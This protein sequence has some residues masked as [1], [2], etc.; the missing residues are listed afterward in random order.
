MSF[1][2]IGNTVANSFDDSGGFRPLR[3]VGQ[4]FPQVRERFDEDRELKI[5]EVEEISELRKEQTKARKLETERTAAAR[6]AEI[7]DTQDQS[8][9]VAFGRQ[10]GSQAAAE[11][12][13]AGG[14]PEQAK[15]AYRQKRFG[16]G[17]GRPQIEQ[18]GQESA[19]GKQALAKTGVDPALTSGLTRDKQQQVQVSAAQGQAQLSQSKSLQTHGHG[20]DI[21]RIDHQVEKD[22]EKQGRLLDQEMDKKRSAMLTAPVAVQ[23]ATNLLNDPV[24]KENPAAVA[25]LKGVIEFANSGAPPEQIDAA[26]SNAVEALKTGRVVQDTRVIEGSTKAKAEA[27]FRTGK[28]ALSMLD[29]A[30]ALVTPQM[31]QQLDAL[32]GGAQNLLEQFTPEEVQLAEQNRSTVETQLGMF[33]QLFIRRIL[34]SGAEVPPHEMERMDELLPSLRGQGRTRFWAKMD[35]VH[36][37]MTR[38]V[39]LDELLATG[40]ITVPEAMRQVEAMIPDLNKQLEREE[41]RGGFTPEQLQAIGALM[42]AQ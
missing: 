8:Q 23:V 6:A 27:D 33:K 17:L 14:T 25:S 20:L 16:L 15:Q 28:L 10:V 2:A 30:S 37:M 3:L 9:M 1:D 38:F 26:A 31:L 42:E 11:I 36:G 32:E 7:L 22:V 18:R 5:R 34:G 39:K 40:A 19:Q 35:V 24:I 4:A 12:L 21:Q 29:E 41:S 13:E